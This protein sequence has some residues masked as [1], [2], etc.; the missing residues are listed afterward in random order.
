[1]TDKECIG[2]ACLAQSRLRRLR[3]AINSLNR[4]A[5]LSKELF[6]FK[7]RAAHGTAQVLS[8]KPRNFVLTAKRAAW[9]FERDFKL[10]PSALPLSDNF[11]GGIDVSHKRAFRPNYEVCNRSVVYFRS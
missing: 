9:A 4:I 6:F 2:I 1:M 3:A 10:R 7:L 11:L 5:R 8:L